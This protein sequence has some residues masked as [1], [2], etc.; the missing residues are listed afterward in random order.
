[1]LIAINSKTDGKFKTRKMNGRDHIITKMM[2]IRGDTAMNRKFYPNNVVQQ[3][4]NQFNNLVAPAGHPV[5]NGHKVGAYHPLALNANNIGG[6]T[7]NPRMKGKEVFV[8]FL[9]DVERANSTEKGTE[10]LERVQNREEIGVSTGVLPLDEQKKDGTDDFG[11]TYT[12]ILN[13]FQFDHIAILPADEQAAG[14]HAGTRLITNAGEQIEVIELSKML[15]ANELSVR[16]LRDQLEALLFQPGN[17]SDF[18]I[19]EIFPNSRSIIFEV[20]NGTEPPKFFR[21]SYAVDDSDTVSLLNDEKEVIRQVT[22]TEISNNSIDEAE[23]MDKEKFILAL[24][25]NGLGVEKSK[26]DSLNEEDL[27]KLVVKQ[28]S[29]EEAREIVANSGFDF[30][31]YD[32]FKASIDEFNSFKA[33]REEE[34]SNLCKDIIANSKLTAEML[35]DKDK[36]ELEAIA[37]MIPRKSQRLPQAAPLS[38][39]RD[40]TPDSILCW[41]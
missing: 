18:W 36:S 6:F 2:P 32:E 7:Q 37:G 28:P 5:I 8:D 9:L 19:S 21:Q 1:M 25:V 3:T 39:Q 24:I 34:L 23:Q 10:V 17:G 27:A 11:K 13:N 35:K 15:I 14:D 22:F 30:D 38:N 26:L 40:T 4:F 29:V 31:G 20:H 41:D 16:D 33:A 12:S